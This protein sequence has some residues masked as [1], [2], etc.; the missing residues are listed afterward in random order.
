MKKLVAYIE[1]VISH[2]ESTF[3]MSACTS[4][5]FPLAHFL[6]LHVHSF[7]HHLRPENTITSEKCKKM[8][9]FF[10]DFVAVK[11]IAFFKDFVAV[12]FK[13]QPVHQLSRKK[14]M[15]PWIWHSSTCTHL[16]AS[17]SVWLHA[18]TNLQLRSTF[19]SCPACL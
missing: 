7:F 10:K 16:Q 14:S 18:P 2:E 3:S 13:N 9:A 17:T 5:S 4:F 6:N 12:S 19:T 8:I 1:M 15:S 11:M